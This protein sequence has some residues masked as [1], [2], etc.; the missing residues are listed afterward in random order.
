MYIN[1]EDYMKSIQEVK[2]SVLDVVKEQ[3]KSR[4]AIIVSHDKNDL[5]YLCNSVIKI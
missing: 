2:E 5:D 3:L 4:S 1:A